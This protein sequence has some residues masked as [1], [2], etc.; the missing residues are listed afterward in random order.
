MES[1]GTG[2]IVDPRGYVLTNYHVVDD[3]DN[4]KV[5]IGAD[6][7]EIYDATVVGKDAYTDISIISILWEHGPR[8]L[9]Q[10]TER[11]L[12]WPRFTAQQMADLIAYLNAQ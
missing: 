6:T 5:Q 1:G 7:K 2:V 3:A 10:M 12:P 9:D 4:I 8:M 11:H